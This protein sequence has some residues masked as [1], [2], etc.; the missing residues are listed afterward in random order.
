MLATKHRTYLASK[1]N[2]FLKT[3]VR[4]SRYKKALYNQ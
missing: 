1:L 2:I 4:V 3:D